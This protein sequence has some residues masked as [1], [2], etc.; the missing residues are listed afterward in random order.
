MKYL[1]GA[2]VLLLGL[3]LTGCGDDSP[4][5]RAVRKEL[6]EAKDALL[7]YANLKKGELEKTLGED[8]EQLDQKLAE[9]RAKASKASQASREKWGESMKS[10]EA[11]RATMKAKLD[12]LSDSSGEAWN[13]VRDETLA[14]W[15]D[16][17]TAVDAA[18]APVIEGPGA[19]DP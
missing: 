13:R 2:L 15:E 9:L 14:A 10:L 12:A 11:K 3:M 16:L 7:K 8:L 18:E 6:R 1:G 17:Q 19:G 5:A 4:E